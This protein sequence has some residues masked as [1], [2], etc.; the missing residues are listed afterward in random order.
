MYPF[1]VV[2]LFHYLEKLDLID[3]GSY[4]MLSTLLNTLSHPSHSHMTSGLCLASC[5]ARSFLLEKPPPVD[6][7]QPSRGQKNDFV[8]RL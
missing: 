6:C 5:L 1:H 3:C 4:T 7:G 2:A 8:C